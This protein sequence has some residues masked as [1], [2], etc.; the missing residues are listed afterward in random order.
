M[1]GKTP[2]PSDSRS[3]VGI[4]FCRDFITVPDERGEP[5]A[6]VPC[7]RAGVVTFGGSGASLGVGCST[8]SP[9]SSSGASNFGASFVALRSA[10]LIPFIKSLSVSYVAALTGRETTCCSLYPFL[11]KCQ[12]AEGVHP[13]PDQL[14][15]VEPDD[16]LGTAVRPQI[17]TRANLVNTRGVT[18]E[19][20]CKGID[21]VKERGIVRARTV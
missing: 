5:T 16:G 4:A 11:K 1:R 18:V 15:G 20:H 7:T 10:I 19:C 14:A 13:I 21:A 9:V 2:M 17:R 6:V 8:I 12:S 3:V